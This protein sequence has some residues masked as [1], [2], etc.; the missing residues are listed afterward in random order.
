MSPPSRNAKPMSPSSSSTLA[1][2]SLV[3][4]F[5]ESE[6][7]RSASAALVLSL[8]NLPFNRKPQCGSLSLSL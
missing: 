2:L 6:T 1:T 8:L 3:S 4:T 5:G 7:A